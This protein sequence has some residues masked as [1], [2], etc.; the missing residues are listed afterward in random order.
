VDQQRHSRGLLGKHL[1]W[2][3]LYALTTRTTADIADDLGRVA[4]FKISGLE[5]RD[6]AV[7]RADAEELRSHL[8]AGKGIG[9]VARNSPFL[10]KHVKSALYLTIEVR[11]NGKLCDSPAVIDNLLSYL[12]IVDAFEYLKQCWSVYAAEPSLPL[13]LAITEYRLG[14]TNSK[15]SWVC[16][17]DWKPSSLLGDTSVR[18]C[19][20]IGWIGRRWRPSKARLSW[21]ILKPNSTIC[22]KR[23]TI[24]Q[25]DLKAYEAALIPIRS[26]KS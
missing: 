23:S 11:V 6:R 15:G 17:K 18:F 19:P 9:F 5:A 4:Q 20:S 8:A 16:G 10:A 25:V 3:E 26:S 22:G 12:Q 7:V 2:Q 24:T 13:P 14:P 1:A 21:R